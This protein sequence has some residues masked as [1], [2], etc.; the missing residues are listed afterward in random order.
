MHPTSFIPSAPRLRSD[1]TQFCRYCNEIARHALEIL[2]LTSLAPA[3]RQRLLEIFP[4]PSVAGHTN[5]IPVLL[6]VAHGVAY[7]N[8][9]EVGHSTNEHG[10]LLCTGRL[11]A[12]CK[13]APHARRLGS[14][15]IGL[16]FLCT[17]LKFF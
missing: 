12:C 3:C 2:Q 5:G 4:E 14:R 15:C 11:H 7:S 6:D 17:V 8:D 1:V 9:P 10:F 13:A 16:C